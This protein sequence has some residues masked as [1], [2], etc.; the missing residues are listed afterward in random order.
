MSCMSDRWCNQKNLSH[1]RKDTE[2]IVSVIYIQLVSSIWVA[3]QKNDG[4]QMFLEMF[5]SAPSE[6]TSPVEQWVTMAYKS[7]PCFD[8]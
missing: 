8:F 2:Q 5:P 7:S 3:V 4:Q 6:Y 1:S